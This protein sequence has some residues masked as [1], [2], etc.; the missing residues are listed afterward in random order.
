[1]DTEGGVGWTT[2]SSSR[3]PGLGS[4]AVTAYCKVVTAVEHLCHLRGRVWIPPS[5]GALAKCTAKLLDLHMDKKD[6]I[7]AKVSKVPTRGHGLVN[8]LSLHRQQ[9]LAGYFVTA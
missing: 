1:M 5:P 2:S 7:Q 8:G 3:S 4:P 9:V 6:L